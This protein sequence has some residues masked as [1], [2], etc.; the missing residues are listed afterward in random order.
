ME[1]TETQIRRLARV[2]RDRLGPP[3]RWTAPEGYPAGLALCLIDA[4]Q[5][6]GVP[7]AVVR[8]V[9]ARYRAYRRAEGAD[10]DTDG[11][12][13]LLGTFHD[14]GS[15]QRWETAIGAPGR[16]SSERSAPA[17]TEVIEAAAAALSD[18]EVYSAADLR[19][20]AGYADGFRSIVHGAW[21]ALP[22]QATGVTWR[23]L[24]ML[25]GVD[26]VWPDRI[27]VH[28]VASALDLPPRDVTPEFAVAALTG[29][30]GVLGV[31]PGALDRTAG[32]WRRPR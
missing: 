13:A 8:K 32:Q 14:L 23:R 15:P 6:P 10:P 22:G 21:T 26:A 19:E 17:K 4:V 2:C 31:P 28:F 9:V 27:G 25:A 29:A 30:A 18:L 7:P 12:V 16:V 5:S 3:N 24:L 20:I 1:P 11:A